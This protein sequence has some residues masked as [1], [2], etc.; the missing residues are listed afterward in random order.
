[1]DAGFVA[2]AWATARTAL[3]WPMERATSEYVRVA[4]SG[5]DRNAS[6]TRRWNAVATTSVGKSN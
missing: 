5:M 2:Q 4:P 1:M 3:G 6:Q